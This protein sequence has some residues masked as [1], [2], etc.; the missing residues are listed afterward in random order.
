MKKISWGKSMTKE[1]A[2]YDL[3]VKQGGDYDEVVDYV[4]ENW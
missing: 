4:N 1:D 2:I 3:H